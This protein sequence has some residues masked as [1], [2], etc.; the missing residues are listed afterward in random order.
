MRI[1]AIASLL[2][3]VAIAMTR[4]SPLQLPASEWPDTEVSTNMV[5]NAGSATE[6]EFALTIGLDAATSNNVE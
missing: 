5:F 1:A 3:F 4:F 6:N 2:P